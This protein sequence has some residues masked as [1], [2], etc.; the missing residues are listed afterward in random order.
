MYL[1]IL[2][3]IYRLFPMGDFETLAA[4]D[5]SVLFDS[6][7]LAQ[8]YARMLRGS[9]EDTWVCRHQASHQVSH[10][11]FTL[12]CSV[13][14]WCTAGRVASIVSPG[15]KRQYRPFP[16]SPSP[17]P[18]LPLLPLRPLFS[19]LTFCF[20]LVPILC[21]SVPILVVRGAVCL[22]PPSWMRY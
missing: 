16:F 7:G 8:N 21:F 11:R 2:Q 19:S 20:F 17:S 13:F 14:I 18:S 1:V 5:I 22:P 15:D 3:A 12:I 4:A 10:K 9:K 6:L